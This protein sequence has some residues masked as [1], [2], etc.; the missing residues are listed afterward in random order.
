MSVAGVPGG[1]DV[2]SRPGVARAGDVLVARLVLPAGKVNTGNGTDKDRQQLQEAETLRIHFG[3]NESELNSESREALTR[4]AKFLKAQPK[5]FFQVDGHCDER[6]STEYN[7]ALGERRAQAVRAYMEGLGVDPRQVKA[8]SYGEEKPAVPGNDEAAWAAN[9][10]SEF[11]PSGEL[12]P[13]SDGSGTGLTGNEDDKNAQAATRTGTEDDDAARRGRK[14]QGDDDGSG[15]KGGFRIPL[16][17]GPVIA[18]VGLPWPLLDILPV[19]T[20]VYMGP[21]PLVNRA[22]E[23]SEVP[24]STKSGSPEWNTNG[25]PGNWAGS[26]WGLALKKEPLAAVALV[27]AV[28]VIAVSGLISLAFFGVGAAV[29]AVALWQY[30]EDKDASQE[31]DVRAILDKDGAK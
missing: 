5:L 11:T 10:R 9:R 31:E 7:L 13:T 2:T 4:I 21:V 17:L 19:I 28:A 29:F 18:L 30:M 22:P 20:M 27:L 6:G 24:V 15:K 23:T 26:I 16:W 25:N 1:R 8:V 3:F 14:G 12:V